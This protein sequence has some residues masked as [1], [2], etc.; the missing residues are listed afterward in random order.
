MRRNNTRMYNPLML[1]QIQ[2]YTDQDLRPAEPAK[3]VN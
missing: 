1:D 3:A 2:V